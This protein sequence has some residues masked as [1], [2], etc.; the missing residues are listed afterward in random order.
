MP[1]A[2]LLAFALL[3][4]CRES[5]RKALTG[6]ACA[7]IVV[8]FEDAF[9]DAPE[10][11]QVDLDCSCFSSISNEAPACGGVAHHRTVARLQAI[12]GEFYA[13]GCPVTMECAKHECIPHCIRGHCQE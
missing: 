9:K 4:G 1:T 8:R 13:A 11:C 5:Q 10:I 3:P 12:A 7:K 2:A 6:D